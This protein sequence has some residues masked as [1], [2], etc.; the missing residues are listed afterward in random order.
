V[1]AVT[2]TSIGDAFLVDQ[3]G[4]VETLKTWVGILYSPDGWKVEQRYSRDWVKKELLYSG[5]TGNTIE[6]GYRE[7]RGGY[8]APAFYQ[9]LKYDLSESKTI[10]FQNFK[11]DVLEADNQKLKFK[12]VA[13]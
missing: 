10:R 7:F 13:D 8:A 5:K 6:I 4:T 12:I 9:N 3:D 2:T 11:I 1:G